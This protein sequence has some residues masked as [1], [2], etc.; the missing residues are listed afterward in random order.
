MS[1]KTLIHHDLLSCVCVCV[2]NVPAKEVPGLSRVW[3][4]LQRFLQTLDG[5]AVPAGSVPELFHCVM[6][7]AW[8]TSNQSIFCFSTELISRSQ[9]F[10]FQAQLT[11]VELRDK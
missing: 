7:P 5:I 4:G 1:T 10:F 8:E 9:L 3:V 2:W 11:A 6:H